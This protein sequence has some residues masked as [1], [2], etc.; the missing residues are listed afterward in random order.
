MLLPCLDEQELMRTNST[1]AGRE[2]DRL[3]ASSVL[4]LGRELV[5]RLLT[6]ERLAVPVLLQEAAGSHVQCMPDGLGSQVRQWQLCTG[7]WGREAGS[8]LV[9]ACIAHGTLATG[10]ACT[11]CMWHM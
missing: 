8:V 2:V 6:G 1:A 10:N 11:H 7:T 4:Q 3:V 9:V 5:S